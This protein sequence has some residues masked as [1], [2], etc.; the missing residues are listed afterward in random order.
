[1]FSTIRKPWRPVFV[2]VVGLAAAAA[3][4]RSARAQVIF[5][6]Y[7]GFGP[8]GTLFPIAG[9]DQPYQGAAFPMNGL[10]GGLPASRYGPRPMISGRFL[11][12]GLTETTPAQ[13][14]NNGPLSYTQRRIDEL[15]DQPDTITRNGDARLMELRDK[16]DKL[17]AQAQVE[18]DPRLRAAMLKEYQGLQREFDRRLGST[19]RSGTATALRGTGPTASGPSPKRDRFGSD[20]GWFARHPVPLTREALGSPPPQATARATATPRPATPPRPAPASATP[21]RAAPAR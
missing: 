6:P 5:G 21:N 13:A 20:P 9:Y 8:S 10:T 12:R 11:D 16:K 17:Y 14:G 4:G 3:L 15:I 1:M 19:G 2:V 7:S 18:R